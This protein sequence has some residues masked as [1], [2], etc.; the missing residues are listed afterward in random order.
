MGLRYLDVCSGI[1]APTMACAKCG[2][3]KPETDFHKQGRRGRHSW[4]RDCFNAYARETR[5]RKVSPQQRERNNLW[6]RYRLRPE[7]LAQMLAAQHG[8]CGICRQPPRR[9]VVDHDHETGAVRGIL[10]H[11]CNIRLPTVEDSAF[12]ASALRYLGRGE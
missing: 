6:T 1:S 4:C 5:N 8:L 11:H 9:P 3:T 12:V 10:C 2:V 7:D